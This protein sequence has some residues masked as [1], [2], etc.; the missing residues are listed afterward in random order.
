[1]SV[2]TSQQLK[3]ALWITE[4]IEELETELAVILAG[5]EPARPT[6]HMTI[7]ESIPNRTAKDK[8]EITPGRR[9]Q[10]IAAQRAHQARFLA[11]NAKK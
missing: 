7:R 8:R 2:L 3:R 9:A 5:N 4:R 11:K 1:M 6:V 10:I